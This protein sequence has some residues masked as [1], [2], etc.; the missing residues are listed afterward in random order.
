MNKKE[1]KSFSE[2][3]LVDCSRKYGNMGCNGGLMNYAF[4]YVKDNGIT[5]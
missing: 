1:I 4:N 3:Q 2:Q 5:E